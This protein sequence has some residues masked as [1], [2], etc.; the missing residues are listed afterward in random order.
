MFENG[1]FMRY[2]LFTLLGLVGLFFAYILLIII[3]AAFVKKHEYEKNSRYYR[4]L[5][6]SSTF[7]GMRMIRIKE[8]VSGIEKIP[9]DSRFLLVCNHRSKFDPII[10]WDILR[11][12]DIAFISKPENFSVPVYG[13]LIRKCCFMGINREDPREA[14]A[15]LKKAAD[16][17]IKDE[18]SVG[19]YPEGT[20]NYGEELLP[21]HNGVFKAAQIANVPIVV[22]AMRGTDDIRKN[23]PWKRSHVYFDVIEV[24]DA[25]YVKNTRTAEIGAR[26]KNDM[27]SI[28]NKGKDT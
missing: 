28:L 2:F 12:R 20:R 9:E 15:T 21:F 18:V 19:V 14:L 23:A 22:A 4:F 17:M 27:E 10:T 24:L 26:V 25:D 13:N 8:H 16:L 1:E 7:I 6:H 5:L 3:S 11:K